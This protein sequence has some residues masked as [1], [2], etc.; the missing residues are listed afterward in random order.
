MKQIEFKQWSRKV[1]YTDS[2]G[3][4]F[5]NGDILQVVIIIAIFMV[6]W[7]VLGHIDRYV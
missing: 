3:Q 6:V 7:G 4:K 5:T 1:R 2:E